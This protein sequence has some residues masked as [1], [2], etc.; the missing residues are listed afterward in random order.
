[1]LSWY[2][3]S[4][5]PQTTT[6]YVALSL[7]MPEIIIFW[8]IMCIVIFHS[9]PLFWELLHSKKTVLSLSETPKGIISPMLWQAIIKPKAWSYIYSYCLRNG[10]APQHA[11]FKLV[12]LRWKVEYNLSNCSLLSLYASHHLLAIV[13]FF[14]FPSFSVFY[15]WE[16]FEDCTLVFLH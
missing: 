7:S 6:I 8:N 14:P 2:I 10:S 5:Y 1:M 12:L 11:R 15:L 13:S 9:F 3:M 4:L 16:A